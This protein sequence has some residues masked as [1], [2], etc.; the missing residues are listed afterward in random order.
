MH[1]KGRGASCQ[2]P[3]VREEASLQDTVK[4]SCIATAVARD[5]LYHDSCGKASCITSAVD[6]QAVSRQRFSS[7]LCH[8]SS[9]RNGTTA[10]C[11]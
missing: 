2:R 3:G 4:R 9:K 1:T 8:D 10:R 11:G 6:T 5:T 7:R